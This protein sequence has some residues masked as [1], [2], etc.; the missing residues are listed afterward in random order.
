MKQT[1]LVV[2]LVALLGG[3]SLEASGMKCRDSRGRYIPCP[4]PVKV[5]PL[6]I[7]PPEPEPP[8]DPPPPSDPRLVEPSV[9]DCA[10]CP[11]EDPVFIVEEITEEPESPEDR[12]PDVS[13]VLGG[14]VSLGTTADIKV[15]PLARVLVD[16]KLAGRQKKRPLYAHVV[17]DLTALPDSEIQLHDASTFNALEFKLGLT[18]KPI[19]SLAAS[20]ICEG[21]FASRF[22]EGITQ[23]VT[24]APLWGGC[25]VYF[26]D[27]GD[28]RGRLAV[29]LGA[30][31]RL[32]YGWTMA[33]Q[34]DGQLRL[35]SWNK[36]GV[37]LI[38]NCILGLES[39]PTR[40]RVNIVRA[41]TGIS[42]DSKAK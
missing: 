35:A 29:T 20:F 11:A 5:I 39:N 31:E 41:G 12:A 7:P 8:V 42:W 26:V 17:A 14:L 19:M 30:D 24:S 36:V 38:V 4:P 23:P 22:E 32:G 15:D 2:A 25:G 18:Y 3:V 16:W 28:S 1:G 9:F 33:V 10:N 21:G 40:Q 13:L 6:R 34:V 37:T 27:R